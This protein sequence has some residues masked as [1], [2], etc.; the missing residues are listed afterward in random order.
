M[1]TRLTWA[2]IGVAFMALVL[3]FL[4]LNV[5]MYASLMGMHHWS[6][7]MMGGMGGMMEGN[8]LRPVA[9]WSL[10]SSLAA[11]AVAGLIGY[12]TARRITRPLVHLRDVAQG[13]DL[14]DLSR[15]VPVEGEDEIADVARAFN[16]MGDRL[17]REERARR[18]LLAD[19]AHE[20]RH[21]LAVLQ[22]R[23]ELMQDGAVALDQEAL[24]PLQDEVIR[25]NRLVGDLRDLSL[26]EVGQL[27]LHVQP[28]F[29][30]S[31][32][33]SLLTNLEPVAA[34]KNI[35]LDADAPSDLPPV[36]GDPDR[37][38]QVLVNLLSNAL[39]YTPEGGQVRVRAWR[40]GR[41]VQARQELGLSVCDTG[42]GISPEDLPHLFERF[43]RVDKSRSRSTGG[44]GLG[45]AIVRSL[46]ELHAG[47]VQAESQVGKGTCIT[48]FLPVQAATE[49]SGPLKG[50]AR[51]G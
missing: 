30:L 14:R 11:L 40:E 16:H 34:A 48:V 8:P 19:V 7:G 13:L 15:R 25:L 28:V 47:R 36:A 29:L 26:A 24:L 21:P 10:L 18:Q 37:L 3:A 43:Y 51:E 46:V 17:E 5:G 41:G 4:G 22:G 42:P 33:E 44:S 27:S 6:P 50:H 1:R 49:E 39:Q 9:N 31:L 38:R 2:F 12:L 32:L 45:L 35:A 23:L 20:L